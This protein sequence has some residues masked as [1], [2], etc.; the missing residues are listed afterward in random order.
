MSNVLQNPIM[1]ITDMRWLWNCHRSLKGHQWK[2]SSC[3]YA[4]RYH[5]TWLLRHVRRI[6]PK[7]EDLLSRI[8]R[9]L[10]DFGPMLCAKSRLPVF[11]SAAW[12]VSKNVL[13]NIHCGLY[14]DPL[15]IPLD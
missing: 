14:S 13:E 7:A 3:G 1:I 5:S 11:N 9:G 8:T 12:H 2:V 15:C 4:L 10:Y 6:V